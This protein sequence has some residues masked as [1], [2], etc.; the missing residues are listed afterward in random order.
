MLTRRKITKE[1]FKKHTTPIE[2]PRKGK[3]IITGYLKTKHFEVI[4][5]SIDKI[6]EVAYNLDNL[7]FTITSKSSKTSILK[8]KNGDLWSVKTVNIK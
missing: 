4:L 1:Q 5:D 6:G 8:V 3:F 2:I 7:E